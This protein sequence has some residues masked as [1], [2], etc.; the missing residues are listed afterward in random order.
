[1]RNA[2]CSQP[3]AMGFPSFEMCR[4]VVYGIPMA[5]LHAALSKKHGPSARQPEAIDKPLPGVSQRSHEAIV[6]SLHTLTE[7]R[8]V[9]PFDV[10]PK[11][12]QR[13]LNLRDQL[14]RSWN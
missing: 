13:L 9:E 1:M 3:E 6:Q 14:S 12:F 8:S 7:F 2:G 5:Q 4:A 10:R 11:I